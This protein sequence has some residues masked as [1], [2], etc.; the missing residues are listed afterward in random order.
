M[1]PLLRPKPSFQRGATAVEFAIVV[2]VFLTMV[3]GILE[4]GRL[5]YVNGTVQE[6]TRRAA[7]EQVVRW[8]TAVGDV[9][10]AA[11]FG[12][13]SGTVALP[14]GGEVTNETV[15]ISFHGTLE[16]AL[17]DTSPIT[18]SGSDP[19]VNVNN[20]LVGNASCIRYVRATLES[21]DGDGPVHYAPMVALFSFL[22]VALPGA[23]VVMP[24]EALGLP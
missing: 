4:F 9:R 12:A 11:V 6:V 8:V 15:Q 17:N 18:V 3:L 16:D 14:A 19:V 5:F 1:R 20:C 23:T 21:P 22:D 2:L 24:A 10:R 13:G 7:R